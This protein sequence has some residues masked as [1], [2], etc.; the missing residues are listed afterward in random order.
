MVIKTIILEINAYQVEGTI[1]II[2]IIIKSSYNN[3]NNN[4]LYPQKLALLRQKS[5]GRS[6]GIVRSRTKVREFSS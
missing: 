5:G 6:V 2:I 3:K 1:T 4:T